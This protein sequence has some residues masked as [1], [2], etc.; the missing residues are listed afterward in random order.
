MNSTSPS[1]ILFSGGTIIAFNRQTESLE[2]IRNGSVLVTGD[3]IASVSSSLPSSIP[4]NTEKVD[5]TDK[6]IT[7]GFIDTHRH[8]WQT[9]FKTLGSNTSL[10]EYFN[11]YSEFSVVQQY[12]LTADDVYY[13]QL[14]G[15]YEALN[16]GVTTTLDHAH[17]TWSNETSE[18]GLKA[19]IDSGARVFWAYAFHD[20]IPNF[21]LEEQF[22]NFRDIAAKGVYKNTP[23]S[24]GVAYDYF[25]PNPDIE[26]VNTVI[27]LLRSSNASVLTT[28]SV[29]GPWGADNSPEDLDSFGILN[30]STPIVFSHASFITAPGSRLLRQT[31]QYISITP[32]SEM[33]YGHGHPTSHLI[34]DQ[35]ALG[36]DTHFTFSTDILTQARLWLQSARKTFYDNVLETWR[37]PVT[38]PMSVNQAF[39]LATR[40]GGRALRRD[41]LGILAVGAKADLVVWDGTSPAL[42][43]WND[44]VAA[45]V[46]HA[47]VGDIEHVVVDGKWKKRDGKIV[48]V[49]YKD[50]KK[51]FLESAK[52]IQRLVIGTPS[53]LPTSGTFQSGFELGFPV[54]A[55]VVNGTGNGYG[56]PFLEAP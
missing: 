2:V 20:N 25:G 32:E 47:S 38:N 33:H 36:V 3:R 39:L 26:T 7:T 48:D 21:P 46:L 29:Q 9:A 14:A 51:K 16:A 49:G 8:G 13:G 17:H 28:H 53:V 55:D 1:S 23:T 41:D 24:L 56:V 34:Q 15:L 19:S 42:L 10:V 18:A 12:P 50:V 30:L 43:G 5:I 11:R 40:N 27:D 35:A 22:A 45:V 37:V 4:A 54:R 31:N 52:R 6:I 44:P